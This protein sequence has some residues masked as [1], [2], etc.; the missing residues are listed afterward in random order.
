MPSE[1]TGLREEHTDPGR[2]GAG[3]PAAGSRVGSRV[4]GSPGSLGSSGL[5]N[6]RAAAAA[7]PPGGSRRLCPRR[8]LPAPASDGPAGG[9]DRFGVPPREGANR[10]A[11]G[12][13][14]A[15]LREGSGARAPAQRTGG[16]CLRGQGVSRV[17]LAK[18]APPIPRRRHTG[19]AAAVT[20]SSRPPAAGPASPWTGAPPSTRKS[21]ESRPRGPGWETKFSK[22]KELQ[23]SPSAALMPG[24]LVLH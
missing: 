6:T 2:P 9:G 5:G 20:V 14:V 17:S 22:M 24:E 11:S 18:P 1:I 13:G 10:W 19:L 3:A 23:A 4:G 16:S 21:C 7:I 15:P 8:E 12:R